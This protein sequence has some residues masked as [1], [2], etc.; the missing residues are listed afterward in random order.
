[1]KSIFPKQCNMLIEL[2]HLEHLMPEYSGLM[3]Q[4][5]KTIRYKIWAHSNEKCLSIVLSACNQVFSVLIGSFG[6]QIG[7]L[8]LYIDYLQKHS[9]LY[10]RYSFD[11]EYE[12]LKAHMQIYKTQELVKTHWRQL[13][14]YF[15]KEYAYEDLLSKDLT[16]ILDDLYSNI[17]TVCPE[18]FLLPMDDE[19]FSCLLRGRRKKWNNKLDLAAPSIEVAKKNNTI[20]RWNPPEKRYL[21]L[22]AGNDTDDDVET[23]C[24]EIR[25]K[26]GE[27]LTTANFQYTGNPSAARIVDMDYEQVTR[28]EIFDFI[29]GFEKQQIHEIIFKIHMGKV[30]SAKEIKRQLKLRENSIKSA[31]TIFAGRLLLKEICDAIFV[32][33]DEKEDND[34]TEKDK[35]YKAFHILAE[36]FESKGFAG[37][38]YPSTRMKLIGRVGK[39][40]VLF[41]ADSAEAVEDTFRTFTR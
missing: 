31:A 21:Y 41:N 25:I 10:S 2:D 1:M 7:V 40:L 35:C 22:V 13:N 18:N 28:Q 8:E 32:P 26:S 39:N 27:T 34:P 17:L 3:Y 20:N 24:Q 16:E 19:K 14:P 33:L 4:L 37:I 12:A 15:R 11:K 9:N 6:E 23:V 5:S 36:F 30:V 29:D 38:C